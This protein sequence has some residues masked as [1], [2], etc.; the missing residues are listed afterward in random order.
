[1]PATRRT[2]PDPFQVRL[3]GFVSDKEVGVGDLI[4]RATMA[5][6]IRP[7]GGCGRRAEALNRRFVVTGRQR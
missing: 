6:G 1:M 2:N 7:C 5:A 3:P 4:K